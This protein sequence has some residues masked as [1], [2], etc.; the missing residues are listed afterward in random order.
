MFPRVT[1][2]E[3]TSKLA[4]LAPKSPETRTF[5]AACPQCDAEKGKCGKRNPL[6]KRGKRRN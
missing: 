4:K 1:S 6:G 2:R 3:E 5:R